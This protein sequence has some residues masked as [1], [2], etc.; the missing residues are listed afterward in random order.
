MLI[1][2]IFL[3]HPLVLKVKQLAEV[4]TKL[5]SFCSTSTVSTTTT[6]K[7][8]T[9]D[10]AILWN[11]GN[12]CQT[13]TLMLFVQLFYVLFQS[14]FDMLIKNSYKVSACYQ[15]IKAAL[16]FDK[17]S[18]LGHFVQVIYKAGPQY[19]QAIASYA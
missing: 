13:A 8:T 19:I 12:F 9:S 5:G 11:A 4:Q 17:A 3:Q 16:A 10:G 6:T 15:I 2:L 1:S 14:S 7:S 18:C